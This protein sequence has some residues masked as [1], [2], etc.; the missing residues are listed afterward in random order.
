[1]DIKIEEFNLVLEKS[2]AGIGLI[3]GD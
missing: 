1:L 2:A 3:K